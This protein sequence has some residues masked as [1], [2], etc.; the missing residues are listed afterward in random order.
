MPGWLALVVSL[1]FT[2]AA[3]SLS[4]SGSH[5]QGGA[6]AGDKALPVAGSAA[7]AG[8]TMPGM[9]MATKA[10]TV[11]KSSAP[12]IA[13]DPSDV[14]TPIT[15]TTPTTVNVNLTTKEIVGQ[16][17]GATTY[18]FWTFNG[19]VPGP[20]LRVMQGDTLVIH[21][22]NEAGS[23]MPH[24]IDFHAAS[25]PGGGAGLSQTLPGKDSTF[26]FKALHPGLYIYHCATQ[27]VSMHI[28]DGMYGMLL[29]EP[30]GGLPKVDHEFYLVQS[31]FYT[32]EP[33]GTAGE[34][35]YSSTNMMDE[36]PTYY[37]FN[38]KVGSMVGAAALHASVGQT[39]RMF[40][41]VG[42]FAPSNFHVIGNIFSDVYQEGA[43]G[44]TPLHNVQT[45]M[46][47]AGGST[48]VEFTPQEPGTYVFVDHSMSHM[49]KGAMGQLVVDGAS[50]PD[51]L[52][53]T[54]TASTG[55]SK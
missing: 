37:V 3:L 41:G 29:V 53:G 27:P 16:L 39:I 32:Q 34:V 51:I 44:N 33:K 13:R 38:G 2:V 26:S 14:G 23:L 20:I 15:R 50:N 31:E 24:S 43:L 45:T 22:H 18:K 40:V 25:G 9:D 49:D 55:E 42:S 47:P 7:G 4:F 28:A 36:H 11:I 1:A 48:I 52:N 46:V 12:S 30:P 10:A 17:D 19:T 21:L 5:S 6:T 54:P 8:N 35:H